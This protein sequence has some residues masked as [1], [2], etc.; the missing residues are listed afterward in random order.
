[1]VLQAIFTL[2]ALVTLLTLVDLVVVHYLVLLEAN[3]SW[4]DFMA[5][6]ADLRGARRV[7]VLVVFEAILAFKLLV[8]LKSENAI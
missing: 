5:D 6:T 2:E 4:E 7:F 1:M 8:A 3:Q